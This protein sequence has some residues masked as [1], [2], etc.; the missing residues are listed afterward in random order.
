MIELCYV[1]IKNQEGMVLSQ[2]LH[3]FSIRVPQPLQN[4]LL[5]YYKS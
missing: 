5:T 1:L 2:L 3:K 4:C